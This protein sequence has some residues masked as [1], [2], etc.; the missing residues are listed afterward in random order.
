MMSTLIDI[1]N[2]ILSYV[3]SKCSFLFLSGMKL[4]NCSVESSLK[5]TDGNSVVSGDWGHF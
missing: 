5:W 3:T 1:N 2:I 4:G